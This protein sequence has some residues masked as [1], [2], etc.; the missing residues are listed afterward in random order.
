[1]WTIEVGYKDSSMDARGN[2]IK[3]AIVE[4]LGITKLSSVKTVEV[5]R[6]NARFFQVRAERIAKELL[7]DSVIQTYSLNKPLP[8]NG[9]W[10]IEVELHPNVTD[11]TAIALIEGIN[12]LLD[13]RISGHDSVR[14]GRKYLLSG[15]LSEKE[16]EAICKNM[17]A[18]EIIENFTYRKIEKE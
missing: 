16:V 6:I 7:H 18:N 10:E 13:E 11:N 15:N 8:H 12:D 4:D 9:D 14:T 5:Y 1:M 3:K 17:L 2:S